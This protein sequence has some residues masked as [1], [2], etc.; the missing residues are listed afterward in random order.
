MC[1][2][3]EADRPLGRRFAFRCCRAVVAGLVLFAGC[4]QD[5]VPVSG[6]VTLNGKPLAGA[7]VIFQPHVERSSTEPTTT[8]SVG[9]TDSEGRFVLRLVHPDRAGAARGEHTVTISTATGGSDA[10]PPKGQR[11]P[12]AWRDVSQRFN[13]PPGG[14]SAANFDIKDR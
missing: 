5:I 12:K 13:V 14:T 4:Q 2:C 7:V 8:G 3:R 6:R 9:H 11:V 1:R 10:L